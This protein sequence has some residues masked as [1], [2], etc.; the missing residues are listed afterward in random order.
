VSDGALDLVGVRAGVVAA[1]AEIEPDAA[2][3]VR[4]APDVWARAVTRWESSEGEVVGWLVGLAVEAATLGAVHAHPHLGDALVEAF[5]GEIARV[6]GAS[7]A[8]L[9]IYWSGVDRADAAY[10]G[11]VGASGALE[12]AIARY[13]AA[14]GDEAP[15]VVV[16]VDAAHDEAGGVVARVRAPDDGAFA[17]AERAV[18]A[19]LAGA[20]AAAVKVLRVR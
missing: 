16:T 13:L 6:R 19:L 9:R 10:R 14:V 11:A 5:A 8:E 18:V 12:N 3:A 7:L 4:R 2:E 17:A 1:L 20:G 15:P